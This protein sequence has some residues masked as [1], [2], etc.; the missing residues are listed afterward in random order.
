MSLALLNRIIDIYQRNPRVAIL[1]SGKGSNADVILS[2]A[3]RYPSV[4]VITIG[5]DNPLSNARALSEK[6]QFDY[7]CNSTT[8][9]PFNHE[10]YFSQLAHYLNEQKIDTLIYAGFMRVS[11]AWFVKQFP[12][13]NVHPADLSRVNEHGTPI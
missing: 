4:N 1:M 7:Y 5:T 6:Y 12:G 3:Y 8:T 9:S 13:F 11:P 10:A 2:Q